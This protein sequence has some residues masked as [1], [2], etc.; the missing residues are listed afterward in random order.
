[1]KS[2][3]HQLLEK[4]ESTE[5]MATPILQ[6]EP[7]GGMFNL[8]LRYFILESAT[9]REVHSR[10]DHMCGIVGFVSMIRLFQNLILC[11]I[12]Q[13]TPKVHKHHQW[14]ASQYVRYGRH[15]R[16]FND[17]NEKLGWYMMWDF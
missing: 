17:F 10:M 14:S 1:M 9:D 8:H 15:R 11:E 13:K 16:H 3:R 7:Q 5:M 6:E 12:L 2:K 4:C